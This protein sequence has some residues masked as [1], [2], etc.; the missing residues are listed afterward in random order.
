MCVFYLLVPTNK[1]S[2]IGFE[3]LTAVIIKSTIPTSQYCTKF[4][5]F[6]GVCLLACE[7]MLV[8]ANRV[9][10][11]VCNNTFTKIYGAN[12]VLIN[13]KQSGHLEY[14]LT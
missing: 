9:S 11:Y 8:L 6:H 10:L 13:I 3:V 2:T 1:F 12:L 5:L 4:L 7:S 14:H